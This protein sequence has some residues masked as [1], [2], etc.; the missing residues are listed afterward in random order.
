M[1]LLRSERSLHRRRSHSRK[2]LSHK[3]FLSFLL[4]ALAFLDKGCQDAVTC[5]HLTVGVTG[6][7]RVTAYL[8]HIHSEQRVMLRVCPFVCFRCLRYVKLA[9]S[10]LYRGRADAL[11]IVDY[12]RPQTQ[13]AAS[14][15]LTLYLSSSLPFDITEACYILHSLMH[16]FGITQVSLAHSRYR[17]SFHV[18]SPS[19]LRAL[20]NYGL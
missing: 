8:L 9:F 18:S 1:L 10:T 12:R 11:K 4:R 2:F 17:P 20:H 7:T 16:R 3:V 6:I 5:A 14:S 15:L 13:L 19:H